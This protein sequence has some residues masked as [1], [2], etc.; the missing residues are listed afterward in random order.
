MK[1]QG[2]VLRSIRAL[3]GKQVWGRGQNGKFSLGYSKFEE[4]TASWIHGTETL[5]VKP[6]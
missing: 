3:K 1:N 2:D 4:L 6:E 5:W